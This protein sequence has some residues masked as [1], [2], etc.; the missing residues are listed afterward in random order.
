MTSISVLI[1]AYIRSPEN[2]IGLQKCLT[3]LQVFA[4]K[5]I[6]MQ[7]ICGDDASPFCFLPE[8][9]SP[10]AVDCRRHAQNLGFSGNVNMIATLAQGDILLLC[11]QDI[12][13]FA[14]SQNWDCA[15]AQ[16]F[17][18]QTVGIVG[19]KLLMSA[20]DGRLLIQNAGG[21][22]DGHSQPFHR[23][24]GYENHLLPEYSTPE[25]VSWTTG[26][27]LA[28]RRSL[29]ELCGG[30]DVSYI[31]GYW[32]DVQLNC[33][34]R[35]LGYAVWYE[36]RTA[37]IHN[38]GSTGGNPHFMQNARLWKERWVD[39]GKVKPDVLALKNGWW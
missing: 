33:Q 32:E 6:Q 34:V 3:S 14:A 31:G 15:I 20:P 7:F 12:Q 38:V 11:N 21:L 36:P 25:P 1:P 17:E 30:L 18:D 39:S 27:F 26:A 16:A 9:L 29:F 4:S 19:A 2:L 24:L 35:E 5:Q 23:W 37:L 28:I 10:C 8:L 22:Y 13:A